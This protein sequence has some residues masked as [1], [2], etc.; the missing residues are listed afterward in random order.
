MSHRKFTKENL[1]LILKD[2][3]KEFRKR[4]G[5]IMPAEIILVGGA[6]I[7][8]NYGFR[9][10]TTDIDAIIYAS[11]AMKE[12]INVVGEKFDLPKEWINTDFINTSSYSMK[13]DEFSTYYKTFSNVLSI[14]TVTGEYLIAMKLKAGRIYKNDLSDIVGILAE[15]EKRNM[16]I[17]FE[18]I[19]TAVQN[20]YGGWDDFSADSR[21]F[22][23]K[24]FINKNFIEIYESV[25]S[26]EIET[27]NVLIEFDKK[28]PDVIKESNVQNILSTLKDKK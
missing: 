3:A 5:K 1:E 11:S 17:T 9:D 6:A 4:N 26:S 20:L 2:L 19:D 12:A 15:H 28:Y 22:I 16:P 25:R 7:L 21:I 13:L 10:M 14:R 27:Q 18:M 8:T 24:A 23:E